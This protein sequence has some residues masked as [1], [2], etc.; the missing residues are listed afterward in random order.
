MIQ[1]LRL[2]LADVLSNAPSR[3]APAAS[4]HDP[5]EDFEDDAALVELPTIEPT[6]ISERVTNRTL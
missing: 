6:A 5:I 1:R 2:R 4:P 3:V